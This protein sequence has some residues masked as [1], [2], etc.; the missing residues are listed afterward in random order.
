MLKGL[1]F[2]FVLCNKGIQNTLL[3]AHFEAPHTICHGQIP[4]LVQFLDQMGPFSR[5]DPLGSLEGIGSTIFVQDDVSN[6]TLG[7]DQPLGE[8][9]M[10]KDLF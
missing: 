9:P 3:F 2:L 10:P 8:I 1:Q 6:I 5:Q 7:G 4:L